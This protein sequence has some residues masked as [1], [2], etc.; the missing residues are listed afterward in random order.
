[1]WMARRTGFPLIG[2]L[3]TAE[4]MVIFVTLGALVLDLSV[5]FLLLFRTVFSKDP[6]LCLRR[7]GGVSL[8]ELPALSA[9]G[10]FPG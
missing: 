5:V 6:A 9:S 1:M 2:R 10:Y 4:P 3:F 8:H 7:R